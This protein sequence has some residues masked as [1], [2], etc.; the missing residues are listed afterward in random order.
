MFGRRAWYKT[1]PDDDLPWLSKNDDYIVNKDGK[2]AYTFSILMTMVA[3]L[4]I[5][6]KP[7]IRRHESNLPIFDSD[8]KP[9]EDTLKSKIL[10]LIS[11]ARIS[12]DNWEF[13]KRIE[14]SRYCCF[15]C[16]TFYE[17]KSYD[18]FLLLRSNYDC[19]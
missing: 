15:S 16:G 13:I 3:F 9:L 5:C 1:D 2:S 19:R 8:G 12:K 7:P 11:V 17:R 14:K 6:A 18:C 10:R 4:E